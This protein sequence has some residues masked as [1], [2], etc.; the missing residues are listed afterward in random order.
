MTKIRDSIVDT[1]ATCTEKLD[2]GNNNEIA[3][4][5]D[6]WKIEASFIQNYFIL[7]NNNH[8]LQHYWETKHG[9][10]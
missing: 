7:C 2:M 1:K 8:S 9:T 10:M 6:D 4:E 3:C 5:I